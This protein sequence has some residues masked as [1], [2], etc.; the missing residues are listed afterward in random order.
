MTEREIH[1]I[2]MLSY[3]QPGARGICGGCG[4]PIIYNSAIQYLEHETPNPD[5]PRAWVKVE[6]TPEEDA[7]V[8]S[9]HAAAADRDRANRE[10]H[11]TLLAGSPHPIL[12]ALLTAHGPSD[13][14]L[15]PTCSEC[16]PVVSGMYGDSE[17][18]DWPCKVWK[19][20]SDRTDQL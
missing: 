9:A 10:R 3:Y 19:F 16:E 15:Y 17:P 11:Q 18:T 13:A 14:S 20:I 5:C 4:Q 6:R 1:K 12:T 7:R 2:K 8:A